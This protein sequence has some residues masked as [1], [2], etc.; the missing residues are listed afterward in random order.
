MAFFL[1]L[2]TL[3]GP[4][5]AKP[6]YPVLGYLPDY[7]T[8]VTL[9][10]LDWND[11]TH[12][13][14]AFAR[15]DG[16]TNIT[17]PDGQRA[18]LVT[19]AHSNNTRCMISFGGAGDSDANWQ[20]AIGA[21]RNK[22]VT[23][24]MALVAA[25]GYDGVDIDWEFPGAGDKANFMSFMNQLAV[26]LHAT[27]GYDGQPRQLTFFISPGY[28]VCG[29]DWTTI[30]GYADY[31]VLSGYDYALS[32]FNGPLDDTAHYTNC[33]GV[34]VQGDI[35]GSVGRLSAMGFPKTQLILGFPF[36]S[37]Q[38]NADNSVLAG[39]QTTYYTAQ[40][41]A[42]YSG[43]NTGVNTAQSFCDKMN[44]AFGQGMP[45]IAMW[46]I[47]QAYPPNSAAV[48]NIWAVIG[49]RNGCVTA[50]G[51]A[52]STP[53][54]SATA[55]PTRTATSTGTATATSTPTRTATS[56]GTSTPTGTP[57]DSATAT[58]SATPTG[59]PTETPTPTD[60]P[61][62]T[63]TPVNSY[64]PTS[65]LTDSPTGTPT[66]TPSHTPTATPSFTPSNTPVFTATSTWTRTPTA[67]ASMTP[68]ASF[69][70]T[71]SPTPTSTPTSTATPL[72]PVPAPV[73]FPNPVLGP[74]PITLA[75][76][77]PAGGGLQVR[78]FTP[79]FRKVQE[80]SFP[81]LPVGTSD[82]SL[83]L[84]D[85]SGTPLANGLYYVVVESPRG[86]SVLKLLLLR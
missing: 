82:L 7:E 38:G 3:A 44:W 31:G 17:Y 29:V 10:T 55:T 15:F 5:L 24:I 46:E 11:M 48:S 6:P 12:V 39:T 16:S 36:Y 2:G 4:A 40:A 86:R 18:N 83:E 81:G 33:A 78:F 77:L 23:S 64:T 51:A 26:T 25:N 63:D 34:S 61:T 80:A 60:S 20:L 52:T 65:T 8:G 67:T 41:E 58:P 35:L 73:L 9:G 75:V 28:F 14:E 42:D 53:T 49:G 32:N 19:T 56:T 1:V 76:T 71:D 74:G 84:K 30:A 57:T 47:K 22:A 72:A 68:T 85:R 43:G 62:V 13:M 70:S 50:F 37:T 59:T 27:V 54:N 69:T 21:N 45:G 66:A 79:A